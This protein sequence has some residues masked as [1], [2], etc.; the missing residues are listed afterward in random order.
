M[1]DYTVSYLAITASN[2][3]YELDP[4]K[5]AA[6]LKDAGLVET[7]FLEGTSD[8]RALVCESQ[9]YEF[10]AFQGTQF[11]RG[12]IPSIEENLKIGETTISNGKN[13]VT[14]YWDQLQALLPEIGMLPALDKPLIITGH[15]MG[16]AIAH[17]FVNGYWQNTHADQ[18]ITFGAPMCANQE[19]WDDALFKPGIEL[20]R[21]VNEDDFAPAYPYLLEWPV[22]PPGEYEW[23]TGGGVQTRTQ[24]RPGVNVS[25]SAHEPDEYLAHIKALLTSP[26]G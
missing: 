6:L 11:S 20:T 2:A 4:A 26:H 24:G 7:A 25:L 10:L 16:G 21:W 19:F 14:G 18:C 1:T 3:A 22:Q 15:S 23:L 17:L 9:D 13:V 8:A 12:E 5:R